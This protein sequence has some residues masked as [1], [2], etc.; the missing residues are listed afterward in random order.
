MSRQSQRLNW[1]FTINNY[2]TEDGTVESFPDVLCSYLIEAHELG[3]SGTPHI[4]GYC[5]L[6]VAMTLN[7]MK[8]FCPTAHF[9][10][11]RGTP[12]QNY[13][14]CAKGDQSHAEW[15]E[16]KEE[17][18]NYGKNA[19]FL[20]W[21]L[22]PKAP[23]NAHKKKARDTTYDQ[24]LAAPTVREG[25]EIVKKQKARDY[26]LHGDAIERHLKNAKSPTYASKFL[27]SDFNLPPLDLSKAVLINGPS[28]FGK[29]QW[30]LAHFKNPLLVSHMDQLKRLGPDHDGI[31][32]DDMSFDHWPPESVIHL[33]D[34]ECERALHVRY[35]TVTIPAYTKKIF[36]SNKKNI[37]TKFDVD[38]EQF[39]AIARRYKEVVVSNCLFS[40]DT[41]FSAQLN[42]YQQMVGAHRPIPTIHLP[43]LDDPIPGEMDEVD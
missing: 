20:E 23:I 9:E 31:V 24:A 28:N 12:Y 35:G 13:L 43:P 10:V 36:T 40:V 3:E 18:P 27:L 30:A 6:K 2:V 19:S 37:F 1:S 29:T 7:Q 41:V 17:G 26:C 39:N 32:F 5:Q 4:Q 15:T 25:M 21:G 11:A 16:S 38:V 14:Y 33:L 22:R 34:M 8:K 42:A